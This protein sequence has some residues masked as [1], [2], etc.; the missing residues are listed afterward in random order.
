MQYDFVQIFQTDKEFPEFLQK[1]GCYFLTLVN[2]FGKDTIKISH[3][4]IIDIY[5]RAVGMQLIRHSGEPPDDPWYRCWISDPPGLINLISGN[6]KTKFTVKKHPNNSAVNINGNY[7]LIYCYKTRY[8]LHF[9]GENYNPDPD[10][11]LLNLDSYRI[12]EELR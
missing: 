6:Y 10:I 3:S 9:I 8:G 5:C 12:I 4:Q 11:D 7:N 1:Y 2:I